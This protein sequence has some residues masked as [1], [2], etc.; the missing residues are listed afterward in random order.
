MTDLK[1]HHEEEK[2]FLHDISSPLGTAKLLLEILMDNLNKTNS[3]DPENQQKINNSYESICKV[4]AII[5][6]RKD[7]LLARGNVN[8]GS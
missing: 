5:K 2:T 3:L 4:C 7:V 1:K 8:E 6:D